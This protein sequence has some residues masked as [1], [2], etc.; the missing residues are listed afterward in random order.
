MIKWCRLL[1]NFIH[2][3]KH[4]L[5]PELEDFKRLGFNCLPNLLTYRGI[6]L[7]HLQH[8]YYRN[9]QEP[10]MVLRWV[11]LLKALL[12]WIIALH[13]T[14]KDLPKSISFVRSGT[15]LVCDMGQIG[16]WLLLCIY[17]YQYSNLDEVGI[18]VAVEVL[19]MH[20]AWWLTTRLT[21]VCDGD[22]RDFLEICDLTFIAAGFHKK[23][24]AAFLS[25]LLVLLLQA[26]FGGCKG[27][28]KSRQF[29][30]KNG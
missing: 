25:R 26:I 18:F 29:G 5:I 21:D 3:Q 16:V 8:F 27:V 23:H 9:E 30:R 4:L 13:L 12:V 19:A 7:K 20:T 15:S 6:S 17:C 14:H 2:S 11:S 22:G 10:C 24:L 1:Y 28:Y